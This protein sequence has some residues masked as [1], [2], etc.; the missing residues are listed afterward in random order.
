MVASYAT[1]LENESLFDEGSLLHPC[2]RPPPFSPG[3]H[4]F[5]S[6]PPPTNSSSR[7]PSSVQNSWIDPESIDRADADDQI[8]NPG[9]MDGAW[10]DEDLEMRRGSDPDQNLDEDSSASTDELTEEEPE[11]PPMHGVPKRKQ[12]FL[13]RELPLTA[14]VSRAVIEKGRNMTIN[15]LQK[16]SDEIDEHNGTSI[17]DRSGFIGEREAD[18]AARVEVDDGNQIMEDDEGDKEVGDDEDLDRD[19]YE[20]DSEDRAEEGDEIESEGQPESGEDQSTEEEDGETEGEGDTEDDEEEPAIAV[21]TRRTRR[22]RIVVHS[23]GSAKEEEFG[24]DLCNHQVLE[25]IPLDV[26]VIPK[27]KGAICARCQSSGKPG[28]VP[29]WH[30]YYKKAR[31]HCG[32]CA[33]NKKSCSFTPGQFNI[34]RDPQLRL[35]SAS[36]A[37]RNLHN[38]DKHV[39]NARKNPSYT[40]TSKVFKEMVEAGR[41]VISSCGVPSVSKE[42]KKA[43]LKGKMVRARV[44]SARR[45]RKIWMVRTRRTLRTKS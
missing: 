30:A 42:L 18:D 40:K 36:Q 45:G 4:D 12:F 19:N 41:I 1:L 37:L 15:N 8:D 32:S 17:E 7:L 10:L 43:R 22:T 20:E 11:G 14:E 21:A 3:H 28:C 23:D 9:K 25:G 16:V 31:I 35:S 29:V 5:D 44:L 39:S 26:A 24:L 33:T 34:G 2:L 38:A 6:T 27:V 13:Q